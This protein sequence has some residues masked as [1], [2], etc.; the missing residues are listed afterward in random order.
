MYIVLP[1]RTG[2]GYD[3]W[4]LHVALEGWLKDNLTT[5]HLNLIYLRP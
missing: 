1:R 5:L 3:I 4:L 2:E